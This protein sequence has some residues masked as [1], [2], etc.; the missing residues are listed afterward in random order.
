MKKLFKICLTAVI[1]LTCLPQMTISAQDYKKMFNEAHTLHKY[2]KPAEALPLFLYISENAPDSNPHKAI[3]AKLAELC[4]GEIETPSQEDV[5]SLNTQSFHIQAAGS[6]RE[7]IVTCNKDWTIEYKPD[8][9]EVVPTT[10]KNIAVLK[11]HE[12]MT[13][14]GREDLLR[15]VSGELSQAI[16][17]TQ[18][19]MPVVEKEKCQV[20]FRC[21]PENVRVT[22]H[23]HL[24]NDLS[25]HAYELKEGKYRLTFTKFGYKRKDTTVVIKPSKDTPAIVMD[26]AMEPTFGIL[27]P[28]VELM[29]THLLAGKVPEFRF[30]VDGQHID[31]KDELRA[32]SFDTDEGIIYASLYKGGKVPLKPGRYKIKVTAPHYQDYEQE[33]LIREGETLPV[34]I[35][36]EL[37]A[38]YLTVHDIGNAEGAEIYDLNTGAPLGIVG[39]KH[40]LTVGKHLIS[41]IKPDYDCDNGIF[42]VDIKENAVTDVKV[43]MTRTVV[44]RVS[45]TNTM[46]TVHING[47]LMEFHPE[48]HEFLLKEGH[49]YDIKVSKEGFWP[50]TE[51]FTVDS[52]V[53]T[54]RRFE[55]LTLESA[56]PVRIRTNE[57]GVRLS[58]Y[59]KNAG[60]DT[61]DYAGMII[62]PAQKEVSLEIPQGRYRVIMKRDRNLFPVFNRTG[63]K[64]NM[65]FN[66]EKKDYYFQT[67]PQVNFLAFG[68]DL[69]LFSSY[70]KGDRITGNDNIPLMGSAWFGQFRLFCLPGLST[71]IFK[72][73]VLNSMKMGAPEE[74]EKE[75]KPAMM[76]GGSALLLNYDFR[77]GGAFCQYG[78][79][80]LLLSYTWYPD[81]S[82]HIRLSHF[83]G[84]EAFGGIELSS[85]IRMFNASLKAGVTYLDGTRNFCRKDIDTYTSNT[86]ILFVKDP[87]RQMMF[88]VKAGFALGSKRANGCNI[89][90]VF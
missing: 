13:G 20:F 54:I 47:K 46:E 62:E 25:S 36:M 23:D 40:K 58:L 15:F 48:Y 41:V 39:E 71:D 65:N 30:H 90:R 84:H 82:R 35:R 61:T 32:R 33:I 68:A 78:D 28:S 45:T 73:S 44:C 5:L 60:N 89:L 64:G 19:P 11:F 76:V 86:E 29:D 74:L 2:G 83:S 12:N 49:E 52:S 67:R 57:A 8:W 14:A 6:S 81:V 3:S 59:R 51:T 42:S 7:V 9:C 56:S 24:Y 79:V 18:D 63:Y 75:D 37:T 10:I 43:S 17:V 1:C 77:V 4:R 38:G 31:L 34:A 16:F 27:T 26:I 72:V 87:F 21:V 69:N 70:M 85:R 66:G 22:I 50:Y 88:T 80:N 53:D 55:G